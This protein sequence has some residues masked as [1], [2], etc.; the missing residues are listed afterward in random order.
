MC[1]AMHET[2]WYY[3]FD[4]MDY[5]ANNEASRE[6]DSF[7]TSYFFFAKLI[8]T[9]ILFFFPIYNDIGIKKTKPKQQLSYTLSI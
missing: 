8:V 4:S 7:G 1:I 3:C 9:V 5:M 6:S 2:S